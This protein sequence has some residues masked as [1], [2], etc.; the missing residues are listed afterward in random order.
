[1]KIDLRNIPPE[2]LRIEAD[3]PVRILDIK[4]PGIEFKEPVNVSILVNR[5]G[6]TLLA[7]GEVKTNV[8][9]ACSRCLKKI[10]KLLENRSFSITRDVSGQTEVDLTP[11][12][13]EEIVLSL[14]VKP[15]CKEDCKGL[16]PICGQDLNEKKCSCSPST[17]KIIWKGLDR[18]RLE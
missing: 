9:L 17:N 13:R 7:N 5:T 18:L 11:D 15:L 8:S 1:M 12:I 2:G 14:P 6:N 3:E 4:V 10:K 16:C